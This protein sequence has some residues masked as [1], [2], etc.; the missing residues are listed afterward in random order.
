MQFNAYNRIYNKSEISY[1]CVQIYI[2]YPPRL[3]RY[4]VC[5]TP[6][7]TKQ[8]SLSHTVTQFV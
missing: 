1:A 8:A 7:L 3:A 5:D 6:D 4:Y 2:F